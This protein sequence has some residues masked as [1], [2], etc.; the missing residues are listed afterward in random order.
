MKFLSVWEPQILGETRIIASLLYTQHGCNK[1]LG[2][3]LHEG[4]DFEF[5]EIGSLRLHAFYA[6]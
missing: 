6:R 4:Q 5:P 2:V 3:P 1:L